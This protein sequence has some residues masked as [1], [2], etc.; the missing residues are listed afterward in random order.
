MSYLDFAVEFAENPDPRCPCVLLLD[1]SGSM[2]GERIEAL[3]NGVRAFQA[4][5]RQHDLARRRTEVGIVTFG[6]GGVQKVRDFITA[7][8]FMAPQLTSGG[9]TPMG[10]AIELALEM[11]DQRKLIYKRNGILYYRPWI[12]MITD[13]EP[14]DEWRQAAKQV[15][16][17]EEARGVAFFAVGVSGADMETLSKISVRAPIRLDGLK[18]TELFVWLSQSQQRV[19]ASRVSDETDLPP[20]GWAKV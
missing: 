13:G 6:Q 12:F 4:D 10:G 5:I 1:T 16:K 3:N 7:E 8:H 14:T 11:V 2:Q 15:Q 20:I 9:A 17:A 19:S 18:F